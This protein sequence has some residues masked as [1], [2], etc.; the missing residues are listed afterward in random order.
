MVMISRVEEYQVNKY[1]NSWNVN[2]KYTTKFS[3]SIHKGEEENFFWRDQ[4]VEL[5]SKYSIFTNNN[6]LIDWNV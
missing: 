4:I 5:N 6:N 3:D 2:K 1:I